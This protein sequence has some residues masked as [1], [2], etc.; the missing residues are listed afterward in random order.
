MQ[1]KGVLRRLRFARLLPSRPVRTLPS[2]EAYARWAATYPPRAHNALMEAEQA[3]MLELMPP[4]TGKRVI[5]L[6]SGTGRY[7]LFAWEG[8]A[9]QVVAVDNSPAMLAQ[10]PLPR[11]LLA[12]LD[13]VPLP[14]GMAD[15]VFCGLALGHLPA[16]TTALA[17][18]SR[19]LRRGGYALLSDFHPF[20]F[21]N[22]ARRTFSTNTGVYAVEHFAHL[23]A[24]YQQACAATSLE[25]EAIREP[26]IAETE[27]LPVALVMRVRKRRRPFAV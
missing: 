23:Y 11:R 3:A 20:L 4:V 12:G 6:G 25:I 9:R 10:N 24:D 17:E 8:G 15:V 18:I 13:A 2:T 16:L 7:G 27:G 19:L 21:L 5:D 14:D 22:G 1:I 26:T